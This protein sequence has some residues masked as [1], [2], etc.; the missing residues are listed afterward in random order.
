MSD[1][2][3]SYKRRMRP[4]VEEIAEALR[5]LKLTVWFDSALEAGV[6]FS[7]EISKE[8]RGAEAV[9]VCWTDDAFPHG[10]DTSGWVVG[11]ASIGR[12]RQRLVPVLL[13]QAELDP[14]WNTL[15]TESLLGWHA[16]DFSSERSGWR[17]VLRGIGRLTGRPG[18]AEYDEALEAGTPAALETWRARY[19]DDPLAMS[20]TPVTLSTSP[21]MPGGPAVAIGALAGAVLT[22]IGA[23]L[24]AG[25]DPQLRGSWGELVGG[26]A[27]FALPLAGVYWRAGVLSP[28]KALLLVVAFVAAFAI[29]SFAGI[30]AITPLRATP[31]QYD[32]AEIILCAIAGLLGTALSLGTFPVLRL[33]SRRRPTWVAIAIASLVLAAVAAFIAAMPFFNLEIANSAIVWLAALWQLCYAPLLVWVVRP[34]Q[35]ASIR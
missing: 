33:A 25:L 26:A 24:L 5:A 13:E 15:H 20:D 6:S 3:I 1:V 12:E 16:V 4:R 32:L 2:F 9:L 31:S 29:G 7:A 10:G 21:Q 27:L 14:P 8:V 19:P 11:E 17:A 30:L 18:L 22:A 34:R 35:A 28:L 23:A